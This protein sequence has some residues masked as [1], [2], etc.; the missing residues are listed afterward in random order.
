M[1]NGINNCSTPS[2]N[3]VPEIALSLCHTVGN[4]G[5]DTKVT[6]HRVKQKYRVIFG[7]L[8]QGTDDISM[9]IKSDVS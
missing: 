9:I 2:G 8:C 5:N 3:M 6:K 4:H 7:F 1:A